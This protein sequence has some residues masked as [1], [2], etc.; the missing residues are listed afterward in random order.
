MLR[1]RQKI[2]IRIVGKRGLLR[3]HI[4]NW[5]IQIGQESCLAL[6]AYLAIGSRSL[7]TFVGVSFRTGS[8]NFVLMS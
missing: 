2:V 6:L 7:V 1:I 3:M 4:V 8:I 5:S